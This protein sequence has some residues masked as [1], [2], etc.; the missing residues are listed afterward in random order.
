MRSIV[1]AA[2][3]ALAASAALADP[4]EGE[5]FNQTRTG[6]IRIAPCPLKADRMCGAISSLT[7]R[8]KTLDAN[9]PDPSLRSRSLIGLQ[10]LRD[11]RRAEPGR[12]TD[13]RI[14]DPK[15][16]KTYDSKL[17]FGANGALKV[18]GCISIVCQAQTWT[19]E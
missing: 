14:Y 6:K 15:S 7:D 11:F 18:Q 10:I 2:A 13:G 17:S 19:R 8:T 5:W 9:N 16:G 1:L 3:L 12:W 4:V